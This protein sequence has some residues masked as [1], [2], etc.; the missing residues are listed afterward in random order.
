M[1]YDEAKILIM[2][3]LNGDLNHEDSAR[4]D[5]YI[6]ANPAFRKEF[7]SMKNL[8]QNL[9]VLET[10]QPSLEAK[11]RFNA[12]LKGYQEGIEATPGNQLSQFFKD[13]VNWWQGSY[14]PQAIMGIALLLLGIQ[15]GFNLQNGNNEQQVSGLTK[16][17]QEMKEMMMLTLMEQQSASQRLRAVNMSYEINDQNNRIT[18]VLLKTLSNDEN[19]N[20]R[21]AAVEA[22]FVLA[23]QPI[24]REALVNALLE[25]ESPIVQSAL[26]DVIYSLQE[27]QASN[28][29]KQ[30]LKNKDVNPAIREKAQNT[31]KLL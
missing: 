7:K 27:K 14:I 13:L 1:T 18:E 17:V 19:I 4:L 26:I 30:F 28:T 29:I 3:Y 9:E 23:D 24:V 10:P 6:N 21:L 31:L 20:V 16:E 11:D 5:A 25:Q 8:W 22:L 15:I 2:E 12:M